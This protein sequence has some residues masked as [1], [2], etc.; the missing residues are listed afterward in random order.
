MI[1]NIFRIK[2]CF[3]VL[4]GDAHGSLEVGLQKSDR[5]SQAQRRS[6]SS[7]GRLQRFSC[8]QKLSL[9]SG[10]DDFKERCYKSMLSS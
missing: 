6:G 5:G 4:D 9:A 3:K 1:K 2:Y 8:I 10:L 7:R